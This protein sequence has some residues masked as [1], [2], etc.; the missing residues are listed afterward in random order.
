MSEYDGTCVAEYNAA[1]LIRYADIW[2]LHSLRTRCEH[3]LIECYPLI[4]AEFENAI[5]IL[6][7][8][9]THQICGDALLNAIARAAF[10][11]VERLATAKICDKVPAITANIFPYLPKKQ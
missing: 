3:F 6:C 2:Q 10:F 4:E 11:G 9:A 8:A 1:I 7:A 5:D